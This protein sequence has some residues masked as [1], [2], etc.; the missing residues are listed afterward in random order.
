MASKKPTTK[1]PRKLA[2]PEYKSFHLQKR[3]KPSQA[4]LPSVMELSRQT[5]RIIRQN[6]RFFITFSLIYGVLTFVFVQMSSSVFDVTEA[7]D[8]LMD[9]MGSLPASTIVYTALVGSSTQLSNQ[10]VGI[11]QF[12]LVLLFSLAVLYG[13]R[14]MYGSQSKSNPVTVKE[15][16]YNGMTPLIPVILVIAVIALQLLPLSL[17][18][19]IYATVTANGLAVT[20]IEKILWL[21]FLILLALLSLYLISSSIFALLIVSL[22]DMAP[23]RALRSA[24]GLVRFRRM[25]V[26]R[27]LL[28]LPLIL[29]LVMGLVVVPFIA[30]A[31]VAAQ[32]AFFILS[33]LLFPVAITYVYNLYRSML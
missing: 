33:A 12:A 18:S 4:K 9:T 23:M 22:P 14:R 24:R 32:G 27:K 21:V 1:Q 30:L 11:Y 26:I 31:P 7:R 16:F 2:D 5:I 3:I 10:S 25:A 6:K 17:G 29:L 15:A 8:I 19:S 28:F 20:E 13:L